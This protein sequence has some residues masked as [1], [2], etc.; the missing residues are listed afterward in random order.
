MQIANIMV[1]LGGDK[2]TTVPK[3][4]V[5]VSEI[6]VLRAIHGNDAVFDVEPLGEVDRTDREEIRRLT[7]E[8]GRARGGDGNVEIVKNLFPGAAARAYQTLDELEIDETFFKPIAH[9]KAEPAAKVKKPKA[10]KVETEA[11]LFDD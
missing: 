9:A 8:Y 4:G 11:S 6:A 5:T 10:A 3:Y 7:D 1:A 2:G